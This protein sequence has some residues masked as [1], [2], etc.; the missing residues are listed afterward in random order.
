M[1]DPS[2]LQEG[3]FA[4]GNGLETLALDFLRVA[5]LLLNARVL[6]ERENRAIWD[7][8]LE[9]DDLLQVG[10][11][12]QHLRWLSAEGLTE[13]GVE[14]GQSGRSPRRFRVLARPV[15]SFPKRTCCV[16]TPCGLNFFR[17]LNGERNGLWPGLS[18]G[19]VTSRGSRT[20]STMAD[21]PYWDGT[22]KLYFRGTL[23][24]EFKQP[25]PHEKAILQAF[26]EPGWP[27]YVTNPLLMVD[28][29]DRGEKAANA[30]KKLNE[31]QAPQLLTFSVIDRGQ[32][33]GWRPKH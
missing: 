26:Q 13:F 23:L 6:A 20:Q 9:I 19:P 16:L 15:I 7:Y 1:S 29:L 21:V 8:A 24:H 3:A 18:G 31:H 17:R 14:T 4:S 22:K 30:V 33:I 25:A 10:L 2:S 11:T 32:K 28:P 5:D 12:H 27:P